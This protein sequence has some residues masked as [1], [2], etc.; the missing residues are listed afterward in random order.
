MDVGHLHCQGEVPISD[1]LRNW[2]DWLWNVHIEDMRRG[3][4][5]HLMF[6]AG[7]ID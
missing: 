4:H 7:E 3:A 2:R 5:D 1:H 6:G